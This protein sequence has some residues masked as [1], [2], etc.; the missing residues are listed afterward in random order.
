LD[1]VAFGIADAGVDNRDDINQAEGAEIRVR[2]EFYGSPAAEG[3]NA[4]GMALSGGGIRSATFA[5]GVV[6]A[7]ARRGILR[8]VDYLSTVSGGGYLGAFI[9]SVLN[10]ANAS[11][12]LDPV[13]GA[14]PFGALGDQESRAVR[15]LRNHGKY[16]PG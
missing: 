10:D 11:V 4:V 8:D 2:R 15:H 12:A 5:L 13:A 6:Q 16:R 14:L 7:F 3:T 9:S 1:A